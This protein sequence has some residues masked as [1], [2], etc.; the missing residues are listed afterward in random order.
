MPLKVVTDVEYARRDGDFVDLARVDQALHGAATTAL[1]NNISLYEGD[2]LLG[3]PNI[4]ATQMSL[5]SDTSFTSYDG[6]LAHITGP[7][8]PVDTTLLWEQGLLDVV[9]DYPIQSDRSNFSIRAALD[10]LALKVVV[11][12]HFLPPTGVD[13]A[14][15]LDGAAGLVRL[16]PSWFQAAWRF[17]ELGFRHI[18]DGTDHLLFL[19]CLVIPFR[20]ARTI[21]PIVTAFTVAH[22]I[23]LIASA[24]NYAPDVLWFPPLIETLI[25]LSIVY[26]AIENAV[27]PQLTRRWIITFLFG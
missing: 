22:S 23:T 17:V 18:L 25:A 19:L 8:I 20:R 11:S 3:K 12:L 2:T 1:V 6:A 7:P 14:Y 9:L 5:D 4:V 13:R 21:I 15:E 27:A 24:F 26:M 16:D 10:R